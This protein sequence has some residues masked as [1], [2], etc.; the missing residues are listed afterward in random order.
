MM[1]TSTFST[2]MQVSHHRNS[3]LPVSPAASSLTSKIA[4]KQRELSDMHELQVK[5]L[6]LDIAAKDEEIRKCNESHEALINDFKFNLAIIAERD[7]ELEKY[8]SA[9]NE[10]RSKLHSSELALSEARVNVASLNEE[11]KSKLTHS[12]DK[13]AQL[14]KRLKDMKSE[15]LATKFSHAE[16]VK[17]LTEKLDEYARD[18]ALRLSERDRIIEKERFEIARDYDSKVFCCFIFI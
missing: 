13:Y 5:A 6:L 12:E 14:N 1:Q 17:R 18:M 15:E 16:E 7:N 10:L 8:E 4:E 9:F 3:S 11:M 2:P